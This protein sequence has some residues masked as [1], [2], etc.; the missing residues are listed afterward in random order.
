MKI[1]SKF[2]FV[3][4]ALAALSLTGC[5]NDDE[6]GGAGVNTDNPNKG[7]TPTTPIEE[8][9]YIENTAVELQ[10]LLKP[11][12]Q[13]AFLNFCRDFEE[14]FSGFIDDDNYPYDP[15][16]YSSK[17]IIDLGR[18]LKK[19]DLIGMT[20]AMQ[21]ISYGFKDIAGVYEPDFNLDEWVKTKDSKNIEFL[22]KVKGMNSS[23]TIVPSGGEWTAQA[24]GWYEEDEYPYDEYKVLYK[25]VVPRNVTVTL[26]NGSTVLMSGTVVSNY[27][28]G[29]HTANCSVDATVTNITLK[30][31]ANLTDTR[32]TANAVASIGG[33]QI[34]EANG[35]LNGHDMCNFDRLMQIATGPDYDDDGYYPD[36][37][38][39]A[40]IISPYNIHTL[41]SNGSANVNILHRMFVVG[42]CDDMSRLAFTFSNFDDEDQQEAQKQ[43]D[44]I[45]QHIKAQFFLGGA[46]SPS[47][48]F[49]WK[50]SKEEENY[51][52]GYS[53]YYWYLEPVMKFNSDGST[54]S[55]EDYFNKRDFA[56]TI[57]VFTSIVNLY[58]AFFNIH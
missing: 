56:S 3:A 30:A 55:F 7:E 20:R 39:E 28:Q 34:L 37:D 29:G 26:K 41:F 17:G 22:F 24:Q 14:E 12:D 2:A 16:Y 40:W 42:T 32:C 36:T 33:Q 15:G 47:G 23:L 5:S 25:I 19:G 13:A 58:E 51:G 52:W 4:V 46:Q 54:Y 11:E 6:K 8:K 48:D 53:Y 44:Y 9:K 50:L 18:S 43:V 57:D 1:F 38:E 21:E 31:T 49:I 45:N 27:N 10:K 35:V